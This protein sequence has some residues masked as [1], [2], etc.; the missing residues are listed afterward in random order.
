MLPGFRL[1]EMVVQSPG[2]NGIV[3]F[4]SVQVHASPTVRII[5]PSKCG[6]A[7]LGRYTLADNRLNGVQSVTSSVRSTYA[8]VQRPF[9]S[10]ADKSCKDDAPSWACAWDTTISWHTWS[11]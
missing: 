3:R 8:P 6:G 10:K 1:T 7:S 9:P 4:I 5:L 2:V 11:D